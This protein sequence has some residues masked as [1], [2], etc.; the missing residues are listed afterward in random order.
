MSL[1]GKKAALVQER[2]EQEQLKERYGI[3]DESHQVE[4]RVTNNTVHYILHTL[5]LTA[6]VAA[7]IGIAVLAATGVVAWTF[8]EC[9]VEVMKVVLEAWE[10]IEQGLKG[11]A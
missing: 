10:Y 4:V 8:P 2:Q 6:R 7:T 11:G 3:E 9:R 1:Y 5:G